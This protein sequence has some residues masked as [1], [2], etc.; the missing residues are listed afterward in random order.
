MTTFYFELY[1]FVGGIVTD[2][3]LV[4]RAPPCLR[5]WEGRRFDKLSYHINQKGG[6]LIKC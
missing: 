6:K 2:M 5:N 3:E 4:Y 1:N